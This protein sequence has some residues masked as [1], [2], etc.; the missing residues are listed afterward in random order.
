[1]PTKEI[2]IPAIVAAELL[3]GAEKSM[4]R[5]RNYKLFKEFLSIYELMPFSENAIEHYAIIRA[6]LER[7]GAL[8]GSNDI[9]I[10][11]IALAHGGVVVSHNTAEFK[12]V[13]G[14]SVEDWALG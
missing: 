2:K 1:M 8:I 13:D 14:L 5:D 10:A 3:Y 7:K 9:I 12:R 4:K 6:S 11:S